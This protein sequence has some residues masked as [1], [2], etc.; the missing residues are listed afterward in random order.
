MHLAFQWEG[1]YWSQYT[2]EELGIRPGQ[3][4]KSGDGFRW[5]FSVSGEIPSD[6]CKSI[7]RLLGKAD[8]P[9]SRRGDIPRPLRW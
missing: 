8:Y 3:H 9:M 2:L 7:S 1:N 4:E 6:E 5:W